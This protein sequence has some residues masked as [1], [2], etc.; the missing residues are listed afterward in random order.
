MAPVSAD[1]VSSTHS[2]A[3]TPGEGWWGLATNF[4]HLAP[5]AA[6]TAIEL[7][8]E[9]QGNQASPV[10]LSSTGRWVWSP[11]PFHFTRTPDTLLLE[12]RGNFAEGC[13]SGGLRGAY[14][15]V[16]SG[17]FPPTGRICDPLLFLAPQYN[18]WIEMGYTPS[19]QGVLEYAENVLAHGFAP[20]VLMIDDGWMRAYGDWRFEQDRF[21]DPRAMVDRLHALG[22]KVMIW[23]IPFVSADIPNFRQLR[24]DGGLVLG[25]DRK[26]V[27]REWWNGFSG[28]V[29][30]TGGPGRAWF[31]AQMQRIHDDYGIDG[32]KLDGGDSNFHRD[33]DVVV[34]GVGPNAHT[35][36][37][38][39]MAEGWPLNEFRAAWK[40]GGK[41]YAQRLRDKRHAWASEGLATLIPHAITAGLLGYPFVCLDMIGGGE[42]DSFRANSARLDIELFVRYAQC[43]ALMPMM[44]FSAAPWR[45]LPARERDLCV[46]A[47]RLHTAWGPRLLAMAQSAACSGE[48]IVRCMEYQYP[49][50][51]PSDTADQY[52]LGDDVL[53][54][55]VV[56]KSQTNRM[57][58]LPPGRWRD[59]GGTAHV[60]PARLEVAAPLERIP[61]FVRMTE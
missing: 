29:D 2:I 58:N 48:P 42:I 18:T 17:F 12:G 47:A 14:R 41:P 45:V 43:A 46:A 1:T 56:I 51:C 44:Q 10:L 60:G 59:D 34:T 21:P 36:A 3:T 24:R 37:F 27:M 30:I 33:T 23:L 7:R 5:Y 4:G 49:G 32:F 9:C 52:M 55:P 35:E 38:A 25:P 31:R 50:L 11:E 39:D 57:V 6:G 40:N 19:Q 54:A 22:F 15:A 13:A 53:V 20:G 8:G 26:P 16:S 28:L 61:H